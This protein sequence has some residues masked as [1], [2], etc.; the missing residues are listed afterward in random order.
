MNKKVYEKLKEVAKNGTT[1]TY[2]DLN[3]ECCL[4]LDFNNINDRNKISEILGEI[5][6]HEVKEG[7][8]MLSALVVL[9]GAIPSA[10]AYGFYA[11]AEELGV[12]DG[13]GDQK[14]FFYRELKRCWEQW[15]KKLKA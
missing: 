14:V 11:Y 15:K 4:N 7:R 6:K 12:W 10:P 13:K 8:P 5:S 3:R 9:K 2:T 1:I